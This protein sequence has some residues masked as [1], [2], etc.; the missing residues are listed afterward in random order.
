MYSYF[1]KIKDNPAYTCNHIDSPECF[2]LSRHE[3]IPELYQLSFHGFEKKIDY[4]SVI[5][6]KARL[7]IR[8]L[9]LN[10]IIR[11]VA[12]FEQSVFEPS[13]LR[14][15][16]NNVLRQNSFRS[17][18]EIYIFKIINVE[19]FNFELNQFSKTLSSFEELRQKHP[20]SKNRV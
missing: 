14:M 5:F 11:L 16:L 6:S 1:E 7:F 8:D 19:K 9:D 13:Y 4:D 2:F 20:I 15:I 3:K 17:S 12:G 18:T 10:G